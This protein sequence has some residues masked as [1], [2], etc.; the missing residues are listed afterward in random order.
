MHVY[1]A[2]APDRFRES[3]RIYHPIKDRMPLRELAQHWLHLQR[4]ELRAFSR[5]LRGM[6]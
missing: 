5:K 2:E 3:N 1:S 6:A 4:Q